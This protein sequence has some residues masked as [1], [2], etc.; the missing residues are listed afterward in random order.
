MEF[1]KSRV[2]TAANADELK[3]GGYVHLREFYTGL[4]YM[5]EESKAY[6]CKGADGLMVLCDRRYAVLC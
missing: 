3:A 6:L 1:D 4:R 5:V 2:Y